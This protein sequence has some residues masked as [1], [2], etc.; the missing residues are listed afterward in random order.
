MSFLTP[1]VPVVI[2]FSLI[3]D[4]LDSKSLDQYLRTHIFSLVVFVPMIMTWGDHD[5]L[6]WLASAHLLASILSLYDSD[7]DVGAEDSKAKWTAIIKLTPAQSV[8]FTFGG[9]V[10]IGALLLMLPISAA[11]EKNINAVDA[12]FVSSSAVSTTGLSTV[13]TGEDFSLF[14]QFVILALVQIGAIGIMT[15]SSSMSILLGKSISMKDRIVMLD[16]LEANSLEELYELILDIVKYTLFIELWGTIILTFGFT[17]DGFEFEQA[18]YQAFFHSIS[19]FC[20]AGFSLFNNSLENFTTN[21]IVNFALCALSILGGLGF[22]VLKELKIKFINRKEH[23]HLGLHSKVI[24]T[25][26][27]STL[28]LGT[29]IVFF[30]E[31]LYALDPY[32]LFD[33]IQISFFQFMSAMTT[34]GFNSIPLTNLNTHTLYLIVLIMFIGA[35]PGSTAGGIKITTL[36][37]LFQS[38]RTTLE[39]KND[40]EFFKR[41]IPKGTVIKATAI[42]IVSLF[43]V[44]AFIFILMAVEKEQSFLTIIFEVYSA[45]GT[46][47][48][49][50][51]ITGLLSDWGKI[52]ITVLMFIGRIGPLTLLLA[53]GERR[54]R[55]GKLEYPEGR[56]MIG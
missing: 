15:L 38:V 48:L 16:M 41:V 10:I 7:P 56:I 39:G 4:Y 27:F 20:T 46:V 50:L 47:G 11:P 44:S 22:I 25:T 43:I 12:F 51:G 6:F 31:F 17:Q 8:M 52:I 19:A 40:V 33:K 21:P 28:F 34:A 26:T 5:F 2:L 32:S 9:L 54:K 24:L 55:A 45:F 37:I 14:G 49:S 18:L 13:S 53:V 29:T 36:A 23:F 42:T 30:S 35:S 3:S 1:L